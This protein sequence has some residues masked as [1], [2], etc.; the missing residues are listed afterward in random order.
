[1]DKYP[2]GRQC[3]HFNFED[4]NENVTFYV[5]VLFYF[6]NIVT[7]YIACQVKNGAVYMTT[8]A[9]EDGSD[10]T[11]QVSTRSQIWREIMAKE[12]NP[13][14]DY[15]TGK[16]KVSPHIFKLRSFIKMFETPV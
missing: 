1:M 7:K 6:V 16:M 10:I 9:P 12:R 3:I 13:L 14:W 15:V 4:T 11:L 8:E 2:E 5:M